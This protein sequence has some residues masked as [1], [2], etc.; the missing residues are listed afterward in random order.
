M[1]LST[2]E[3]ILSGLCP[4]LTGKMS[5]AHTQKQ[6]MGGSNRPPVLQPISSQHFLRFP[7]QVWLKNDELLLTR[8]LCLSKNKKS[9]VT[10]LNGAL[11]LKRSSRTSRFLAFAPR[12]ELTF[13]RRSLCDLSPTWKNFKFHWNASMWLTLGNSHNHFCAKKT[14]HT[15][16][17]TG[18]CIISQGE[19][20][21]RK[22]MVK[23]EKDA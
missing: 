5:A 2:W 7:A 18:E 12:R 19:L 21:K 17:R 14:A 9:K 4:T 15:K 22:L 1:S 11:Q 6:T 10:E 13:S 3:H 23:P 20:E 16:N 8:P